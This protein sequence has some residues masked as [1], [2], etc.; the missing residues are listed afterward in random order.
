MAIETITLTELRAI[1]SEELDDLVASGTATGGSTTTVVDTANLTF[2]DDQLIDAYVYINAGNAA[3]NER[4]ITDSD[5][6][7]TNLTVRPVFSASINTSSIYEVHSRFRN[8][9]LDRAIKSAIRRFRFRLARPVQKT[10][11]LTNNNLSNGLFTDWTSA[12]ADNWSDSG[13]NYTQN[14]TYLGDAISA[15]SLTYQAV[16]YSTSTAV[17]FE[18]TDGTTTVSDSHDG[19]GWNVL[20]ATLNAKDDASNI[21]I[22][23]TVDTGASVTDTQE[24]NNRIRGP[25][26]S[27]LTWNTGQIAYVDSV[28]A[29]RGFAQHDYAVP[30]TLRSIHCVSLERPVDSINSTDQAR[31]REVTL[32]RRDWQGR[33]GGDNPARYIHFYGEPDDNVAVTLHGMGVV[34]IPSADSDTIEGNVAP[35]QDWA[36]Y[37]LLRKADITEAAHYRRDALEAVNMVRVTWPPDSYIFDPN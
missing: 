35:Y 2:E 13:N 12:D 10:T 32:D 1:V 33:V 7:S 6:S 8:S 19:T 27:K 9:R 25:Y 11:I 36:C 16:V 18:V 15:G 28:F 24:S 31:Q 23:F 20:K 29:P 3:G 4:L 26:S 34:A 22:N 21:T 5:Q 17:K 37:E 30:T 14:V